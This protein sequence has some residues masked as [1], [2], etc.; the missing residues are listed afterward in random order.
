MCACTVAINKSESDKQLT[1]KAC[2]CSDKVGQD[3]NTSV[4]VCNN[5]CPIMGTLHQVLKGDHQRIS[6][7]RNISR[8]GI[9]SILPGK[10]NYVKI[11][12]I[13][14]SWIKRR[15]LYDVTLTIESREQR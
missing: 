15:S 14:C 2:L 10:L 4:I 12:I 13:S 8:D 5:P 6:G 11:W 9:R 7:C 1:V 3:T